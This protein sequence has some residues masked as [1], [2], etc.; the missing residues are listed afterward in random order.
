MATEQTVCSKTFC[1]V[2]CEKLQFGC[3]AQ[4]QCLQADYIQN[5]HFT[6]SAWGCFA[7]QLSST[8][9][10]ITI[11]G[12]S[13]QPKCQVRLNFCLNSKPAGILSR[14]VVV[15]GHSWERRDLNEGQ[16]RALDTSNPELWKN[17]AL[18]SC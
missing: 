17:N 1:T 10:C 9:C 13:S 2:E 7:D 18:F 6:L 15:I 3:E 4:E 14:V 12:V 8:C 16:I 11:D 5:I